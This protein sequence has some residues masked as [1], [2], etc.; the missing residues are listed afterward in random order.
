MSTDNTTWIVAPHSP[1]MPMFWPVVRS[2][3]PSATT[4]TCNGG[5]D[6]FR[7]D[8]FYMFDSRALEIWRDA[9]RQAQAAGTLLVSL[10]AQ[11]PPILPQ[12]VYDLFDQCGV[13]DVM[14][15]FQYDASHRG[16]EHFDI[17]LDI[18][19]HNRL[20]EDRLCRRGEYVDCGFSRL[21]C[22]QFALNSGA[23]HILLLGMEGYPPGIYARSKMTLEAVAIFVASCIEVCPDVQFEFCGAPEYELPDTDNYR[24]YSTPE[25]FTEAHELCVSN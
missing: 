17:H 12:R 5:I 6:V 9:A 1:S 11:P 24:I 10:R 2:A 22:I 3:Y 8:Y 20:K 23:N 18:G 13:D 21:Y 14:H 15:H 25:Q 19:R 7:P 4:I 16:T